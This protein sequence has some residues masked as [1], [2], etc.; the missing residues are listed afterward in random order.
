[1]DMIWELSSPPLATDVVARALVEA[2]EATADFTPLRYD[3]NQRGV[4]RDYDHE[5]VI[6]DLLTQRTQI[7]RIDGAREGDFAAIATGKHG[8][9]PVMMMRWSPV[10]EDPVRVS[11]GWV[12]VFA[13]LPMSRAMLT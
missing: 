4:Y 7:L 9:Q 12:E 3:L 11:A 5:H 2:I 10:D 6:V 1:M 8:E 13:R